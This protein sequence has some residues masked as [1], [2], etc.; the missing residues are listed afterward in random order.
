M[1]KS[2]KT[3]KS[4]SRT[5]RRANTSVASSV[6]IDRSVVQEVQLRILTLVNRKSTWQGTMS[7]LGSAL[8]TVVRR[9]IP[10]NFPHNPS[11]L[12]RVVNVAVP[13]L[14]RNGVRV[15]FSRTTDHARTRLV[16]FVQA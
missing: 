6:S 10:A 16:S 2:T 8:T 12:R 1:S 3:S 13:T 15:E 7:Q 4:S 14:R 5:V 11:Y 9:A